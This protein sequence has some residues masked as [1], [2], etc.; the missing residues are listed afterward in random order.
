MSATDPMN[1][2][3][4][5]DELAEQCDLIL[6]S[7]GVSAGDFDPVRDVLLADAKVVFWKVA[8]KPGKPVML[9]LYR[10]VPVLPCPAIR[11]R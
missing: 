6:T 4:V 11:R 10:D 1:C 8:M 7:G 9:A 3:P 2:A 5:L